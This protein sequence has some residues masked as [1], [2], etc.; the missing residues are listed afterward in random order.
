[1]H[2]TELQNVI[3]SLTKKI[4]RYFFLIVLLT[5]NNVKA[6]PQSNVMTQWQGDV[7]IERLNTTLSVLQN[8][9]ADNTNKANRLE[10][11]FTKEN[12]REDNNVAFRNKEAWSEVDKLNQ[13]SLMLLEASYA[14]AKKTESAAD[15]NAQSLRS[16]AWD[17]CLSEENCNFKKLNEMIDEEALKISEFTK[18]NALDTQKALLDSID[19]L[20]DFSN[21]S[22]DSIGLN[23]SID[24]LSKVNTTQAS[25]LMSLANQITNLTKLTAHNIQSQKE[26]REIEKKA[27]EL[28]FAQNN[29]VKSDH[30]SIKLSDYK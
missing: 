19:K 6:E 28:Y 3:T 9:S 5:V 26:Q 2:L 7:L 21:Q 14:F 27:E 10:Q 20:N 12:V 17:D 22:R 11:Y 18:T 8:W 16:K 13:N 24:T 4:N 23:D 1:M 25:A 30:L 29:P 15:F